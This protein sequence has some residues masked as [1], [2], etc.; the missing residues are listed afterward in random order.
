MSRL[1]GQVQALMGG[2]R[3]FA[4]ERVENA[5]R[6]ISYFRESLCFVLELPS[7]LRRNSPDCIPDPGRGER[8]V[9]SHSR[10]VISRQRANESLIW[11]HIHSV[12][13][14]H[15]EHVPRVPLGQGTFH[16]APSHP[17]PTH[18]RQQE[19]QNT[20]TAILLNW[21]IWVMES[22]LPSPSSPY[23]NNP[24]SPHARNGS[25]AELGPRIHI[26]C[27]IIFVCV[28]RFGLVIRTLRNYAE[29][30]RKARVVQRF[31]DMTVELEIRRDRDEVR[32]TSSIRTLHRLLE[33]APGG[34]R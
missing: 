15:A 18:L 12:L 26:T 21:N 16:A 20:E 2:F 19:A 31:A 25:Y 14:Q 13:R 5:Q 30:C 27:Q 17:T 23:H 1:S 4:C 32:A 22:G 7:L 11:S 9:D 6:V 3:C 10:T 8:S 28:F 34:N 24:R 33:M 29:I